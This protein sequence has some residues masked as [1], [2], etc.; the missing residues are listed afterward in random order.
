MSKIITASTSAGRVVNSSRINP[1][2][3]FTE[4]F[5]ERWT[6]YRERWARASERNEVEPFPLF[7]RLESQFKCNSNCAL[8][9]HGYEELKAEIAYDDYM[10]LSLFKRLVDEC[11]AHQCPSI[12]LSF[13]N[14]PLMDPD[15]SDRLNYLTEAKIMDIHL[16]SNAM[17]LTPEIS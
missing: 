17:L 1:D 15:F 4:K 12:A 9:V 11:V 13:I 14:E 8:C 16:N 3:I 2:E 6:A 10:P 7:V 5:G